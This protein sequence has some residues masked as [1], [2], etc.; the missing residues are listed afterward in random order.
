M[1]TTMVRKHPKWCVDGTP[2]PAAVPD[3]RIGALARFLQ[4]G[5]LSEFE[6]IDNH[7]GVIE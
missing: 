3:H 4:L 1:R 2:V 6:P 7:P 5:W